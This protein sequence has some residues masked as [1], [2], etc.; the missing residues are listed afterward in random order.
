MPHRGNLG[1]KQYRQQLCIVDALWSSRSGPGGNPTHQSNL[2]AMG[3]TSPVV[4]YQMATLF[5]AERMGWKPNMN[6]TR[7]ILKAFG[8]SESNLPAGGTLIEV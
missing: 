2:I 8:Y 3:V 1:G 6:A 5:R 4:D 7:K